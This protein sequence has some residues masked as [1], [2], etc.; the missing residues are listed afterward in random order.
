MGET[1]KNLT[2]M[3]AEAPHNKAILIFDEAY[4]LLG[5]RIEVTQVL[6]KVEL[7]AQTKRMAQQVFQAKK[8][9]Q[10]LEEDF[11]IAEQE[12][13]LCRR[14]AQVSVVDRV[15]LPD[16]FYR[17]TDLRTVRRRLRCWRPLCST[18]GFSDAFASSASQ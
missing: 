7:I 11:E 8:T 13:I 4:A 14:L 9:V 6:N 15:S 12:A 1:E 16:V 18:G 10:T 5:R 17:F 3:F 2:R